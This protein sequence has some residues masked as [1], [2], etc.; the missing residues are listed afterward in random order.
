[1]TTKICH[2]EPKKRRRGTTGKSP[3]VKEIEALSRFASKNELA[4]MIYMDYR[5]FHRYET[6]ETRMSPANWELIQ[7]KLKLKAEKENQ[8]D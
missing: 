4:S 2:S 6:G 5:Q 7:I 3:S 8:N 1:M